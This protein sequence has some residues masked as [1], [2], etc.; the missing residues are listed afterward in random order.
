MNWWSD[1]CVSAML[2]MGLACGPSAPKGQKQS[3]KKVSREPK[4]LFTLQ[5]HTDPVISV[6]WSP[7]GK[8][9]ASGGDKSMNVWD[10]VDG[11]L[12]RTLPGQTH[13]ALDV[14]WSPDRQRLASGSWDRTVKVVDNASGNLVL[15]L[16]GHTK[17]VL[18]VDWSPDG[19]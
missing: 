12:L 9:I 1:F 3:G 15:T 4:L 8:H 16:K 19:K 17:D 18:S 6:G 2:L 7:D 14:A 13:V 11:K 5:G 10:A